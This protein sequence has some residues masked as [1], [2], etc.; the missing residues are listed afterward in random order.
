MVFAVTCVGSVAFLVFARLDPSGTLSGGHSDHIAHIGETRALAVA[1]G[2]LWRNSPNE[3]FRPVPPEQFVKLPRDIQIF[4]EQ[5]PPGAYDAPG[6]PPDRPLV[7]TWGHLPKVYPPGVFVIAAPSAILHH[8]GL[9][10]L[11]V[12][13]RIFLG[14]LLASWIVTVVAWLR[15]WT[16]AQPPSLGRQVGTAVVLAFTWYW[17]MEGMYDVVAVGLATAAVAASRRERHASAFLYWGL[18][19]IVH[20]RLLTL[21][22]LC[23]LPAWRLLQNWKATSSADRMKAGAGACLLASALAFAAWIQPALKRIGAS[24]PSPPNSVHPGSSQTL[25]LVAY[26]LLVGAL[27]FALFRRHER[28]D[29]IVIVVAALA[30]SFQRHVAPWYFL[31]ILPWVMLPPADAASATSSGTRSGTPWSSWG[32]SARWALLSVFYVLSVSGYH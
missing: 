3:L 11:S 1:P 25:V 5:Y 31:P 7:L 13:S 9:V 16:K 14:I 18:A 10:S 32:A 27:A 28:W 22:P 2:A 19:V 30:Y 15:P 17:T 24:S 29:A 4:S 6:F 23:A 21:A 20:S 26:A 8:F 12:A